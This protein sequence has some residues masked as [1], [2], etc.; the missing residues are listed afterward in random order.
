M[1]SLRQAAFYAVMAIYAAYNLLWLAGTMFSYG[2]NDTPDEAIFFCVTF[3]A[4]IPAF[5][6]LARKPNVGILLL[7]LLLV[8]GLA[9]AA[10]EKVL[11]GFSLLYWYAPK[12]VPLAMSVWA[13]RSAM[14]APLPLGNPRL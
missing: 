1:R 7:L 4:D 5:F 14:N 9:F 13:S 3:L 12:L 11:S 10:Y 8:C 6:V 2:K